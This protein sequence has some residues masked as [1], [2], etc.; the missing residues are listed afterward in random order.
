M[1]LK[2]LFHDNC[3][4]GAASGG[5][6][7]RFYRLHVRRDAEVRFLGLAHGGPEVFP[8]GSFDADEH[9]VVDFRYSPRPELTWWFDHHVSAFVSG[10]EQAH[11]DTAQNERHFYDPKA[12]SCTKF[13]TDTLAARHGFDPTP[14]AELVRWAD[15]I[16]GAQFP[17]AEV[18]V[19]LEEPALLL[20]TWVEHNQD[21]GLKERFIADIVSRP[22]AEI[23]AEDYVR[24]PLEGLLDR[25]R[26][27]I[28][29]FRRRARL[30]GDVVTFDLTGDDIEA[31]NKFI[32]YYLF[33]QCRY[34][35]GLTRMP[36]RLKISVGSNPWP[37]R[38][39]THDI[40][41]ICERYG[42]GGHPVVG[43]ISLP[44]D[45]LERARVVMHEVIAELSREP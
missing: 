12:R 36:K 9:A 29:V 27:S 10:A 40:A 37:V 34:T 30:E 2:V 6:F 38:P 8:E 16:D 33:P 15:I 13:L 41:R 43:A 23:V 45:Q 3:F 7:A 19:E 11:F 5:L 18:A 39:R 17:S 20:M 24:T 21:L 28:D 35:V 25:H 31:H 44:A 1:R 42:G 14:H 32:A 26:K 22:F 4:D